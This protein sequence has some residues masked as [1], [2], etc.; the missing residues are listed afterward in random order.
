MDILQFCMHKRKGESL[1]VRKRNTHMDHKTSPLFDIKM[2]KVH[3]HLP[4][5]QP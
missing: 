4:Q 1:E 5:K 2:P 3:G